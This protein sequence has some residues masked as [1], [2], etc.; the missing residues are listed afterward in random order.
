MLLS[1]EPSADGVLTDCMKG[2]LCRKIMNSFFCDGA[3]LPF[4]LYQQDCKFAPT[5]PNI[6]KCPYREGPECLN[7]K[8]RR[9]VIL[10]QN[11]GY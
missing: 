1:T 4:H 2:H 9:E 3:D 6:N 8:A 7:L 10:L 5:N 11:G